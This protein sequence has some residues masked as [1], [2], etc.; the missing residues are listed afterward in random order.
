MIAPKDIEYLKDKAEGVSAEIA[1]RMDARREAEGPRPHSDHNYASEIGHPCRR[2]LFY[3]RRNWKDAAPIGIDLSYRLDEGSEKEAFV[4]R[5]LSDIGFRLIRSQERIWIDDA[6][7]S[8]KIDGMIDMGRKKFKLRKPFAAVKEIPVE[9]KSIA[10]QFW[11]STETLD[12]IRRHR[13]FWIAKIPDQLN[14]YLHATGK[15][16]GFLILTTWARRP[17]VLPM[18]LDED[19]LDRDLAKARDVNAYIEKGE[20]PP[21]IPYERDVCD[22]CQF[23]SI[24][25]PLV[26]SPM[27]EIDPA[28]EILLRQ[29]VEMKDIA[30]RF[31]DM[32]AKLIGTEAKPG[33]YFGAD[34]IIGDI[35]ITTKTQTRTSFD[36][37]PDVEEQINVIKTP[38]RSKRDIRITSIDRKGA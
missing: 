7:I 24:C 9:I 2:H 34:A 5:E 19:M 4:E 25:A 20:T 36:L 29:F 37:P 13:K 12:D 27:R 26:P 30:K 33:R 10:P 32:K 22:L 31:E 35:E 8:G 3:L 21:P 23:N 28:D 1:A 17:R 38:F 16:F 18:I 14:L 11:D 6:K 15:P